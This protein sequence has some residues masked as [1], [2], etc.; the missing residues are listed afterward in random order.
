MTWPPLSSGLSEV[1]ILQFVNSLPRCRR[2]H[3]AV[4]WVVTSPALPRTVYTSGRRVLRLPASI[5]VLHTGSS[6]HAIA[7]DFCEVFLL[8]CK[9]HDT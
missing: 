9:R 6:R 8:L 1:R 5:A 4:A 2:C 3:L 7:P